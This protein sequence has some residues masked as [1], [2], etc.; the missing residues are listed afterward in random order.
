MILR[1]PSSILAALVL[2]V[3]FA[4]AAA[5]A[6]TALAPGEAGAADTVG[7]KGCTGTTVQLKP[8][9][10]RMLTLHNQKRADRGL[11]RLCVHP[12]LQRAARA[13]SLDMI[14]K[15]YFSHFSNGGRQDPGERL[16]AFGYDWAAYGENIAWGQGTRASADAIFGHWMNREYPHRSEILSKRY[17][18]VGIGL[19]TGHFDP[20]PGGPFPDASV[21]TVDF[22]VRR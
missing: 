4:F 20:G 18:E 15:D 16:R 13:H 1:Q 8:A 5:L 19:V 11:A 3:A 6:S 17:R 12:K 14:Q 7:V 9:E 22:G 10:K 2:G 21:W